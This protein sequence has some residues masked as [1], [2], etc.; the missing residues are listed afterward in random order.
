MS[1]LHCMDL[2][3]EGAVDLFLYMLKVK[4]KQSNVESKQPTKIF[5]GVSSP[6][7]NIIHHG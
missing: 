2:A 6:H 4:G 5:Y 1:D 3:T 7:A